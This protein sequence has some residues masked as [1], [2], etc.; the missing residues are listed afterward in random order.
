MHA[1]AK[2]EER[3]VTFRD[4]RMFP[5]FFS[6]TLHDHLTRTYIKFNKHVPLH[7]KIEAK[8]SLVFNYHSIHEDMRENEGMA[9]CI[10]NT[11][12]RHIKVSGQ[13]SLVTDYTSNDSLSVQVGILN[14]RPADILRDQSFFCNNVPVK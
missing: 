14:L 6:A 8:L 12:T 5:S 10:L 11:A 7:G 13:T 3:A 2:L 4:L 1:T 9:P